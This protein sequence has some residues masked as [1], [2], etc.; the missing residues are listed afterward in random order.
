MTVT[1]TRLS[2]FEYSC[3]LTAAAAGELLH[4]CHC[5]K[6]NVMVVLS[7]DCHCDSRVAP[8]VPCDSAKV[9]MLPLLQ[10]DCFFYHRSNSTFAL[11]GHYDSTGVTWLPLWQHYR[12]LT[13]AVTVHVST[14]DT[15][16]TVAV[17]THVLT[18]DTYDSTGLTWHEYYCGG[19]YMCQLMILMT[20]QVWPDMNTT[21]T[22]HTCVN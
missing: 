18:N 19:T 3:L 20:V 10:S 5:N 2:L 12:Y 13:A 8:D 22:V 1:I 21:V 17:H 15:Y 7:S 6:V 16:T 11:D 4:N 9:T 14:N